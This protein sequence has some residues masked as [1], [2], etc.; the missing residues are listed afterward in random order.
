VDATGV[1]SS[2]LQIEY[3]PIS[4]AP[5]SSSL[6]GGIERRIDFDGFG[7]PVRSVITPPGG[8]L[9]VLSVT[10]Y[11]GF[12]GADPNGRHVTTTRFATAVPPGQVANA[13]GRS[14]TL[15]VDEL[16]RERKI[17]VT[18]GTD[19]ANAV[20]VVGER[21]YDDYGRITFRAD[22]YSLGQNVATVYGTTY[23]YSNTGDLSCVIRGTGPQPIVAATDMET[24]RF[25]TCIRH[26][27]VGHLDTVD[28]TDAASLLAGSGQAGVVKRTVATAAGRIIERLAL[29]SGIP[30]ERSRFNYDPL[31]QVTSITRFVDPI[32]V[33]GPVEWSF[34]VDSTGQ[35]VRSTQPDTATR[36]YTYSDWR[37]PVA[38]EWVDGGVPKQLLRHYD[39]LG[40]PVS[41]Q[42][43]TDG[44]TDPETI[45]T[46]AYDNGVSLSPLVTPTFVSGHL[47]AV[48]SA[49]GQIS[50]SYNALGQLE[51]EVFKA[52]AGDTYIERAE[53]DAGGRLQSLAFELPDEG[54]T[55]ELVKY[56]YDSAGRMRGITYSDASGSLSL[57]QANQ[58][59]ALGRVRNALIGGNTTLHAAYASNGRQQLKEMVIES[60]AGSRRMLLDDFDPVGRETART[61]FTN[62]GAAVR[63]TFEYDRLGR[64]AH[65]TKTQGA[66]SLFNWFYRYDSIGNIS[67]LI[68]GVQL[69]VLN[70]SVTDPDRVCR[71]QYGGGGTAGCNVTYDGA[72]A[73][74]QQATANGVRAVRYFNEG[75]V[76]EIT[77]GNAQALFRY[78]AFGRIGELNVNGPGPSD[79]RQSWRFGELLERQD[80]SVNGTLTSTLLRRIPGPGGILF[81]SRRGIGQNWV[82]SF[83][84]MRANRSFTNQSGSFVQDLNYQPFGEANSTGAGVGSSD[85]TGQQWN[86]GDTLTPFNLTQLGA[87]TYDPAIG[88][89]LS[90]DPLVSARSATESHP[91]AFAHNDPINST[92]PDGLCA[93]GNIG[94]ECEYL[95]SIN[96]LAML[97]K[98]W[99][100][101]SG[102]G[103][104]TPPQKAKPVY[105]GP[106]TA[107]GL[108]L[109]QRA[110]DEVGYIPKDF[111]LDTMAATGMSMSDMIDRISEVDSPERD[112][113]IDAYNAKI[114]RW[115]NYSRAAG[116]SLVAVGSFGVAA[117]EAGSMLLL[118]RGMLGAAEFVGGSSV[119]GLLAGGGGGAFAGTQFESELEAA[120]EVITADAVAARGSFQSSSGGI[121]TAETNKVGGTVWTSQGLINQ[122][123]V[124]TAVNNAMTR[125]SGPINILTGVH[126]YADG[127]T[128]VEANFYS[129]DVARFGN[130]PGVTIVNFPATPDAQING[131]LN[132]SGTTI[133]A[134]CNSAACL[135][136]FW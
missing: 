122:N 7:R 115:E 9:G 29:H 44:V 37:E 1:A 117:C 127:S 28:V 100:W 71:I 131:L 88:R 16:S 50:F 40:R 78:D 95:D 13:T 61:E 106:V 107:R 19:Y 56:R 48:T 20:I 6:A 38:T 2:D 39:A 11:A 68:N 134:F 26:S 72:G 120:D 129:A 80:S 25:P 74:V 32:Q 90:R 24:E 111:N 34:Q 114:D 76:R 133:G 52:P 53:N 23:S 104:A 99:D 87:R 125:G 77:E 113:A 12:D 30:L 73:I 18:L 97:A 81:A 36:S 62:G 43:R 93:G 126:G 47:A 135:A 45:V 55:Q 105:A 92:D 57:Y 42:E 109:Q 69:T 46:Y 118:S 79:K 123:D 94:N 15:F 89:F 33:A 10:A 98:A 112:A 21:Q 63:F 22:P 54:F 84:E 64:L 85:Y 101:F 82:F 17:E 91:Y 65:A 110:L 130:L 128:P 108:E 35:I 103:P 27:Y 102:G 136:R 3:D 58:V 4:L 124:G 116:W 86:G 5:L 59:D 41:T 66:A 119:S 8:S 67:S 51:A 60:P 31:G 132:G 75:K 49:S 96:P 83:G 121:F 14:E 70:R